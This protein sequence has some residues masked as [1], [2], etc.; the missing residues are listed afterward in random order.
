LPHRGD[1]LSHYALLFIS[2]DDQMNHRKTF[3]IGKTRL[4]KQLTGAFKI[5]LQTLRLVDYRVRFRHHLGKKL[6][7][8]LSGATEVVPADSFPIDCNC[9]RFTNANIVERLALRVE[10]VV[11][12]SAKGRPSKIFV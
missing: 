12:K 5:Q 7:G 1:R 10:F 2:I 4:S 3:T 9:Q 11:G 8:R 6:P